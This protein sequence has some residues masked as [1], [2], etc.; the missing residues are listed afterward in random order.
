MLCSSIAFAWPVEVFKVHDFITDS[1]V[2]FDKDKTTI[3]AA[4]AIDEHNKIAT[5]PQN[6]NFV[7]DAST[8]TVSIKEEIYGN[9]LDK[10]KAV[11]AILGYIGSGK[12]HL[13]L[14]L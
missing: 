12:N 11:N 5:S 2:N 9:M 3:I 14:K 6:A 4:Q 13:V 1:I 7:C 8:K 10:N